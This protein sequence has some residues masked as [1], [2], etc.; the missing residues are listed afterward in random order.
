MDCPRQE[1][2]EYSTTALNISP[3]IRIF[4]GWFLS[5][6]WKIKIKISLFEIF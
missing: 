5:F 3:Q 2:S 4:I 6:I 1:N